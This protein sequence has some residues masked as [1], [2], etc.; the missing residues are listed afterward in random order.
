LPVRERICERPVGDVDAAVIA[1]APFGDAVR[2]VALIAQLDARAL[3]AALDESAA[4][5]CSVELLDEGAAA[6]AVRWGRRIHVAVSRLT[7]G[8]AA[9]KARAADAAGRLACHA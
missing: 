7:I 9:L 5:R 2:W 3:V 1:A 6:G 4:C 8:C